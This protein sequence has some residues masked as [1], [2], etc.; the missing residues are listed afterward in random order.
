MQCK[1]WMNVTGMM[2]AD[3]SAPAIIPGNE[4]LDSHDVS[5][6]QATSAAEQTAAEVSSTM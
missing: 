5:F 2:E 1:E 3:F 4:I 6:A